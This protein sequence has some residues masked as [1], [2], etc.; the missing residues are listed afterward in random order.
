MSKKGVKKCAY[1]APEFSRYP[2]R[3]ADR[4]RGGKPCCA[5][6]ERDLAKRAT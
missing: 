6:C 2:V 5:E 3:V 4:L 1:C